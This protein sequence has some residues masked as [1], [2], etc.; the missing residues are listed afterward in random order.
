MIMIQKAKGEPYNIGL[1]KD[2]KPY[3]THHKDEAESLVKKT[4]ER[5][6][7]L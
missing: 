1:L 6:K 3:Y 5:L 2:S 7:N 4:N